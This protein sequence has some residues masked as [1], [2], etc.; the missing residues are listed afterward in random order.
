M[1]RPLRLTTCLAPNALVLHSPPTTWPHILVVD[2]DNRLRSLLCNLLIEAQF[3]VTEA[4]NA[5]EA[6]ALRSFFQFDLAVM[7]VMMPG[8]DGIALLQTWRQ[9]G[10]DTPV[11]LLTALG[12]GVD[13]VR[14]LKAGAEDYLVKPFEPEELVLRLRT[15]VRHRPKRRTDQRENLDV[16]PSPS[17]LRFG[18]YQIDPQTGRVYQQDQPISLTVAEQNF[19]QKLAATPN[20]A[21]PRDVLQPQGALPLSRAVDVLVTRLRKRFEP[22]P[23]HPVYLQ[24]VHGVGYRLQ[25]EGG[26]P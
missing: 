17:R 14:G 18:A 13:R 10:D 12:E 20:A 22:D 19:L 11:L 16:T 4:A 7:D 5:A 26:N 1:R 9:S 8:Q 25:V 24:T 3:W 15:M 2:D 21:V 23:S 6:L